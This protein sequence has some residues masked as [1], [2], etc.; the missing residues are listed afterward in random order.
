MKELHL[1]IV[2]PERTIYDGK[3]DSVVLPGEL[4]RFQVLVNHA[5]IISSLVAGEVRYVAGKETQSLQLALSFEKSDAGDEPNMFL[6][7][8]RMKNYTILCFC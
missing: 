1:V 8:F 5:P 7:A 4:G 2:S 3:A 6:V